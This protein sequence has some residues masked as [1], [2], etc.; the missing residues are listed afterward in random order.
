[1][2]CP[3][4]TVLVNWVGWWLLSHHGGDVI[5]SLDESFASKRLI[6]GQSRD[7]SIDGPGVSQLPQLCP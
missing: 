4:A 1:M 7:Q 6:P 5:Y 3:T 2:V